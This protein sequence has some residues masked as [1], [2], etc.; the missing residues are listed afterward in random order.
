MCHGGRMY[1]YHYTAQTTFWRSFQ[2]V[3]LVFR[4]WALW[5]R[6]KRIAMGLAA[7]VTVLLAVVATYATKFEASVQGEWISS[8]RYY[9][10]PGND[11][12]FCCSVTLPNPDNPAA[13]SRCIQSGS[14]GT[15]SITYACVAILETG[16]SSLYF[17]NYRLTDDTCTL[18]SCS[19]SYAYQGTMEMLV[20]ALMMHWPEF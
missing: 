18:H 12:C 13:F 1:D 15:I 20:V 19:C 7:L 8:I 16:P 6:N 14:G 3:I 5:E 9:P 11:T 10:F 4:T 2:P 17:W